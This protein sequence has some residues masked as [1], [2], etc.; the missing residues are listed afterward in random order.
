MCDECVRLQREYQA[1]EERLKAMQFELAKDG[2]SS[3]E[4]KFPELWKECMEALKELWSLRDE[5]TRHASTHSEDS[6][7]AHG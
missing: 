5:M 7:S 6:L 2:A 4:S 3:G 1:A